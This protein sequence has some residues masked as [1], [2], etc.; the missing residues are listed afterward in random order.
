MELET[1]FDGQTLLVFLH[2]DLDLNAADRLRTTLDEK[3]EET[4]AV[5]LLVDLSHVAFIDSSGLGVLLGRYKQVSRAGGK[6]LLSGAK[7]HVRNILELSGLLR[8]M[9]DFSSTDEA[10]AKIG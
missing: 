2:G 5:N 7:P 4:A 8:I 10:L 6:V 1:S 3:L 9:E